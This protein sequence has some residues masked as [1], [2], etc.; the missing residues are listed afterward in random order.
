M[1]VHE[2]AQV[3]FQKVFVDVVA[4]VADDVV[5]VVKIVVVDAVWVEMIK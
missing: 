3:L 4:V 2:T 5:V 1:R